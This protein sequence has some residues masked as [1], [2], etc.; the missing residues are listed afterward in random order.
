MPSVGWGSLTVRDRPETVPEGGQQRQGGC[1]VFVIN[2][3]LELREHL[4]Q[5]IWWIS[6]VQSDPGGTLA[7]RCWQSACW[8]SDLQ[9][10]LGAV[11]APTA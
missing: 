11:D 5:R 3:D 6:A 4:P 8:V 9:L 2:T 10:G 1:G 7:G